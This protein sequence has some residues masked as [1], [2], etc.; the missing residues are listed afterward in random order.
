MKKTYMNP[1]CKVRAMK[2]EAILANT[3]NH[4]IN[5][6]EPGDDVIGGDGVGGIGSGGSG[7]DPDANRKNLWD[8]E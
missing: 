1:T 8:E 2:I 3:D 5:V 4:I 6:T 7:G